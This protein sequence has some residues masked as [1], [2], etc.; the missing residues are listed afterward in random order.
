MSERYLLIKSND[1]LRSNLQ[2]PTISLGERGNN[3]YKEIVS[4]LRN[5]NNNYY[6]MI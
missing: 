1:L 6:E 4:P 3:N 5:N 2:R